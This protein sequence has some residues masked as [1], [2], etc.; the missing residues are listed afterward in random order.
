MSIRKEAIKENKLE[1]LEAEKG[2]KNDENYRE[3]LENNKKEELYITDCTIDTD[4]E[5]LIPDS[6]IPQVAEKIRLYKELDTITKEEDLDKFI[7]DLKDR[8]GELPPQ[9]VQLTYVVRLRREAIKLGFE[10]IVIKNGITLAYF[11]NNQVSPYYKSE[12]F[13][14]ILTYLNNNPAKFRVKEQNNK[15]LL[16]IDKADSIEKV[17]NLVIQMRFTIFALL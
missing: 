12:L 3:A 2:N 14:Q 6:Y 10:R 8:F 7:A 4:L 13:T 15:L 1:R 16:R 5:L 17:Y 11:V 9:L